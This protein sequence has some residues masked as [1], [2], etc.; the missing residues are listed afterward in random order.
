MLYLSALSYMLSLEDLTHFRNLALYVLCDRLSSFSWNY[1]LLCNIAF[2]FLFS[3]SD[4]I[5]SICLLNM[6][7]SLSFLYLVPLI[8]STPVV[9]TTNPLR[10]HGFWT[11][12]FQWLSTVFSVV[13]W[14]GT[15]GCTK[16]P[17]VN[18]SKESNSCL[19]LNVWNPAFSFPLDFFFCFIYPL[20]RD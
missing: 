14:T 15:L 19:P 5:Y 18:L 6:K 20:I 3:C 8:S 7:F 9:S 10:S 1:A 13:Y 16:A 4:C 2:I 12:S 17:H 11:G